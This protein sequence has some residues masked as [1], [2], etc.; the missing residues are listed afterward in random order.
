MG[1]SGE[2]IERAPRALGSTSQPVPN[3]AHVG[4]EK[5]EKARQNNGQCANRALGKRFKTTWTE[6]KTLA[7]QRSSAKP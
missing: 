2:S 3:A 7:G 5:T 1:R 6:H 4:G